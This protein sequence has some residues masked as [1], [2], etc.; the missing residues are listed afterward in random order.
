MRVGRGEMVL[1]TGRKA[2]REES[3]KVPRIDGTMNEDVMGGCPGD[4]ECGRLRMRTM[5]LGR[6]CCTRSP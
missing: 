6:Q 4:K 2:V 3:R 1:D 5:Y